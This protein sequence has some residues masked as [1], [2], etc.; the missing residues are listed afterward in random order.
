MESLRDV[1]DRLD[2]AAVKA[3]GLQVHTPDLD[4]VFLALTGHAT[5]NRTTEEP[6]TEKRVTAP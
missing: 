3:E 4:D 6:A 1:L 2:V 5:E